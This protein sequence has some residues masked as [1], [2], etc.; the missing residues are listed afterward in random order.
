MDPPGGSFWIGPRPNLSD[1]CP[2][3]DYSYTI[4]FD[5]TNLK[6]NTA[7]VTGSWA[8]DNESGIWLNGIFTGL[9]DDN[10][11]YTLTPFTLQAGQNVSFLP[12]LNTLEFRV[13]NGGPG[14]P[15]D[16]SGLLV[17]GLQGTAAPVPIPTTIWLLG[18]G[19]AGLLGLRR[20]F[21]N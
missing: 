4:T 11:F 2:S 20:K 7:I 10:Q 12:G 13:N 15:G 1:G 9:S 18:A 3:G 8:S 6:P 5:L 19:L 21:K 17:Y 14:G 16:P